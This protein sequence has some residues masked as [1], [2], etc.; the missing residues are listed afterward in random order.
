ME[1]QPKYC[2]TSDSMS[3]NYKWERANKCIQHTARNMAALTASLWAP[4][5][6]QVD[7]N[8]M[9]KKDIPVGQYAF[10][11]KNLEGANE[12][13]LEKTAPLIGYIVYSF[14][15]LE[16]LLNSAIC[17]L[18]HDDCDTTGLLVIYR[19]NYAAKVD[20]FKR[21]LLDQQNCLGKKIPSFDKLIE[22]LIRAGK[23]RNTVVHA[24]WESAHDDGYTLCRLKLNSK[25]LQHE[26]VQF[27]PQSLQDILQLIDQ[28]CEMFDTYEHEHAELLSW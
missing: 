12:D 20:L 13:F 24:D 2:V 10:E 16:E 22:N 7:M 28:T 21:F 5:L 18:F 11:T 25:G 17:E 19:M 1:G 8:R 23:L 15:T 3:V 26:Y 4:L 9:K 6:M 14:N 27:T